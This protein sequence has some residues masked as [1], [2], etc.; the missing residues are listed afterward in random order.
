MVNQG[1]AREWVTNE[2]YVLA[3][4][5]WGAASDHR[6]IVATFTAEDK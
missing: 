6:P 2:T 1:M 5:N 3:V 4:S